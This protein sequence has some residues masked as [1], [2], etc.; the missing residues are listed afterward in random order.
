M[1]IDENDEAGWSDWDLESEASSDSG[2]WEEVSSD[3]DDLVIS[4]SE[5]EGRKPKKAKTAPKAEPIDVAMDD[6]D[7]KSVVSV[8]TT[9]VSEGTKKLSLLA[10]QKVRLSTDCTDGR[11]SH[12]LTSRFLPSFD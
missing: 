6:D 7:T 2:G 1:D 4:D 11:F 9:Q 5:D 3:G 10:Q 12:P 8:A